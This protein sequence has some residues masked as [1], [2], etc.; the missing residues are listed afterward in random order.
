MG[1]I[2]GLNIESVRSF[3]Q[4]K[5][6]ASGIHI[7]KKRDAKRHTDKFRSEP[8]GKIGSIRTIFIL[9]SAGSLNAIGMPRL[10]CPSR[11]GSKA[12]GSS[13]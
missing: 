10:S 12:L 1:P 7:A 4:E 9:A 6:F 13:S 3:A 5:A 2:W 8:L 11:V